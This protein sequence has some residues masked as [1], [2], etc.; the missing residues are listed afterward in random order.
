MSSSKKQS[1]KNNQ[2]MFASFFRS[3]SQ[4][5]SSSKSWDSSE[6]GESERID[7]AVVEAADKAERGEEEDDDEEHGKI[8]FK[9][10]K[11]LTNPLNFHAHYTKAL[12]ETQHT[13]HFEDWTKIEMI[14]LLVSEGVELRHEQHIEEH[15]LVEL[16]DALYLD[17]E[18]PEKPPPTT[19]MDIIKE[20]HAARMLQNRWVEI[21]H[22]RRMR[23]E[24]E[25]M[26]HHANCLSMAEGHDHIGLGV[27]EMMALHTPSSVIVHGGHNIGHEIGEDHT[28]LLSP[29]KGG[30]G[31]GE[32]VPG[33][34]DGAGTPVG[35]PDGKPVDPEAAGA[36]PASPHK[37]PAIL[38]APW[39][40]PD[41]AKAHRYADYVQPRKGG[42]GGK[43][44]IVHKTTTGRHC[45]LGGFGE[46]FDFWEEGQVSEFGIY[47]S[48]VT[49][50]FKFIKWCF[51]LF[52]VLFVIS[53]PAIVLNRSGPNE[54]NTGLRTLA[55]TT[56][57]NLVSSFANTTVILKIPGCNS[58]GT[59]DVNCD[60]DK[61]SLAEFYMMIDILVMVVSF[62][63]FLWLRYFEKYEERMLA[64]NTVNASMFTVTI[65]RLPADATEEELVTHLSR[66]CPNHK[67][68]NISIAFD[69]AKEI[70]EC[71]KRGDLIRAKVRAVHEHR[72]FCTKL[73]EKVG[74]SRPKEA[75]KGV[76]KEREKFFKRMARMS[77]DLKKKEALLEQYAQSPA[78]PIYAFVTF[79]KA[80]GKEAVLEAFNGHPFI[81]QVFYQ[82]HLKLKDKWLKVRSSPEPSTIL[83]ENLAY[84]RWTCFKR[85]ALTSFFAFLLIIISLAMIFSA[86]YAE[87]RIANNNAA[88]LCPEDFNSFSTSEKIAWVDDNPD[89]LSCYCDELSTVNQ[90]RSDTCSDYAR[91]NISSQIL[92]YFASFSVL[93][94]NIL[95]EKVLKS[96]SGFEK[97]NSEDAR[98][99]STFLRLFI[100]KYINTT[101]VF[102]INNNNVLLS[103]FF[104]ISSPST[105]E[106]SSD[107]YNTIGVT[108]ILVQMGDIFTCHGDKV[109]KWYSFH[110]H[111]YVASHKEKAITQ[112]ELNQSHVGPQFEFAFEYAQLLSTFF[113]CF[114]FSTGIPILYFLAMCNFGLFYFVE[115]YLFIHLYRIPPHFSNSVGKRAT[116]LLPYAFILHLTM[117]IW[118]LSSE[119]LFANEETTTSGASTVNTGNSTIQ[120][121]ITGEAIFPLFLLLVAILAVRIS[122]HIYKGSARTVHALLE[123]F[124]G[125][126]CV[127]Q[128]Q[129]CTTAGCCSCCGKG[130]AGKKSASAATVVTYTR[131]VQRNLIKG[132]STYNILQNPIYKEKFGITW[133][134]AMA[135]KNVRSVRNMKVRA[136]T[137]QD[138]E[139]A[140]KV[141]ALQRNF[142]GLLGNEKPA[143]ERNRSFAGSFYQPSQSKDLDDEIEADGEGQE[144]DEA[145]AEMEEEELD[146]ETGL[147]KAER[148]EQARMMEQMSRQQQQQR[149]MSTG[150]A[151]QQSPYAPGSGSVRM[152]GPTAAGRGGGGPGRGGGF[153]YPAQGRGGAVMMMPMHGGAG[154]GV[155]YGYATPYQQQQQGGHMNPRYVQVATGPQGYN[156]GPNGQRMVMRAQPGQPPAAAVATAVAG[157]GGQPP[158]RRVVSYSGAPPPP[159]Y[160]PVPLSPQQQQQQQQQQVRPPGSPPQGPV[161]AT[162]PRAQ[163]YV[164]AVSSSPAAARAQA[165]YSTGGS[166]ASSASAYGYAPVPGSNVNARRSD[167]A[168]PPYTQQPPR[169]NNPNV[170]ADGFESH[171]HLLY[172]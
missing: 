152:L 79:D 64:K 10:A 85:R 62:V 40:A 29:S 164:T 156:A 169:P 3:K 80:A 53:F 111:M 148:A 131:A 50:Y 84:G 87:Q 126:R 58:Y 125:T 112:E 22:E 108:V 68:A 98:G 159:G 24:Q 166:Y 32:L 2:S 55:Q 33:S 42:K 93:L 8:H 127:E 102:F 21:Q 39:Q 27:A 45:F 59:Y 67:I 138:E 153:V 54:S 28:H 34:P 76:D 66:V 129:C 38:D 115:K 18:M 104:G 46:Q 56:A 47:G 65:S 43:K 171:E 155:P 160:Y 61:A 11:K 73:R 103:A 5:P 52:A 75:E 99:K 101:L 77:D 144:D 142:K 134:F 57:G 91:Q 121:K 6:D 82:Q 105:T 14:K 135:N 120:K 157:R 145:E 31:G 149:P 17:R 37:G 143:M 48:G 151:Y 49:N 150:G 172:D 137:G 95:I 167:G 89:Q 25:H 100:L 170:D 44:F 9:K 113:C 74:P 110:R 26:D 130:K 116:A 83:W 78:S 15:H 146:R 109:G 106:F 141:D 122:T 51:W 71:A 154:A 136:A 41:K 72:K 96:L 97:H 92:T 1:S 90:L 128:L 163:A 162:S 124:C 16:C 35:S 63:A 23:E 139:D 81:Y 94:V 19:L 20:N 161:V 158:P 119:E 36:G 88:E 69:N 117:S 4:A 86:K 123:K 70:E 114:T 13:S 147:T 140:D 12:A 60:F 165:V 133:K 168:P 107:W 132:L 30:G 7:G 118:M